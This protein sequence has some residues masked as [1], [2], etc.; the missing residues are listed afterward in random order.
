MNNAFRRYQLR[1]IVFALALVA[2][3]AALVGWNRE[4]RERLII[5]ERESEIGGGD[6]AISRSRWEWERLHDPNLG[7]IPENIRQ[8]E[9]QFAKRLPTREQ[10]AERMG[11]SSGS[12]QIATNTW[13]SR[14][15]FNVG[16]RTRALGIDI[17]NSNV[18]L[19]GGVSGGMWRSSDGGGSW[20]KTTALGSLQSVSCIAQ[21][22]RAS[23]NATW[24]YGTGELIGNSAARLGILRGDGIFKSTN[25]G[26]T[27][28]LLAAT[29]KGTLLFDSRFKYIWNVAIDPSNVA[30]DEVYAAHFGGISRSTDGGTTWTTTLGP[31]TDDGPTLNVSSRNTDVAVASNGVVYAALGMNTS[32]SGVNS[33]LA[34]IYRSPDGI[35]WTQITPAGFPTSY[36]RIVIGIAPSNPS[37]V[38]FLGETPGFGLQVVYAGS[39]NYSSL[40]KYT[41]N[42]AGTGTWANLSANLPDFGGSVGGFAHQ[43]GYDLLVKV[44][45]D[46]E[47]FV[48]I[49]GTNLYRS[50]DGFAST[51]NSAWIGGYSTDNNVSVYAGQH[52]DQ[53]AIVFDPSNFSKVY[54]GHDAGVSLTVNIAAAPVTWSL[55]NNGYVTGQF[56]AIAVD[57]ATSSN[58]IVGGLQDNGSWF[59][60]SPSN[61][62]WV[63]VLGGDGAF[64]AVANNSSSYYMSFQNGVTYRL[65]LNASG[66]L[67]NF[68]RVDP[69]GATST[70]YQFINP[71]VLD[72]NNTNIMYLSN[73]GTIWRNSDLTAVPLGVSTSNDPTSVNWTNLANLTISGANFT[74]LGPSK[75]SPTRLYLGTNNGQVY[76]VDNAA[77]GSPSRV[78]VFT[79][80]GFPAA[81]VSSVGVDPANADR[82]MITFSNYGVKSLFA[83]SDAG[84]NWTDVGGNLEANPDGTGGGPSVRWAAIL[85]FA[86]ISYYFV[87]TSIGLYSTTN[88]NGSSTVWAQEGASVMGN[89]VVDMVVARSF[90]GNVFVG[91]HGNGVFSGMQTFSATVYP[92]DANNDKVVDARDILPIGRYF[93][94]TG[95]ARPG[96][97]TTW[98]A[99]T[100]ST[101][102]TKADAW[103]ADCNGNGTVD[104][105]DVTVIISN[106]RA[107]HTSAPP[108]GIDKRAVCEELL[109]AIDTQPNSDAMVQIRN[110]ITS[111]LR[112]QLGVLYTFALEQNYP[113]PFNPTTSISFSLSESAVAV[114]LRIFDIQGREVWQ[115][116]YSDLVAGVHH[117]IWDGRTSAGAPVASGVYL[118][119]LVAGGQS[120]SRR[121]MFL[122]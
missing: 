11:K 92:G 72:P 121:M 18:L 85:P 52:P 8:Q 104:G 117:E 67:N 80:K 12:S 23:K 7:T 50:T 26:V 17:S 102:W 113:N 81:F 103:Y 96:A 36:T 55:L 106:W 108:A 30:Q 120:L 58:I 94:A 46:N 2:W 25:N 44:K 48:L 20:T 47:N 56:Y 88:L 83:T 45:P 91:T 43:G 110:A 65:L 15:P 32:T 4:S 68:A 97:S 54:A 82:A 27:W 40:W 105:T 90:D 33:S 95:A 22:T 28:A 13:I 41:D 78:D 62:L 21:D 112:D 9:I 122:K 19:A 114:E 74:A 75:T 86:G 66:G 61:G 1:P 99:Q 14:G 42:G 71:Y 89:V 10:Q 73:G 116:S 100:L 57:A 107:T 24:Y 109:R 111:Y 98:S 29:S 49:G 60:N 64:A 16:G 59:G 38:Y 53:H 31:N 79:G 93:G 70:S 35:T 77:T 34:G 119:Q 69:S 84:A 115:K 51:A 37:V 39:D 63:S 6:D 118:Y 101:A 87:G 5:R 3:G 76:R